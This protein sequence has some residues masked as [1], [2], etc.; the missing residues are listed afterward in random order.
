MATTIKTEQRILTLES[1]SDTIRI[2][3]EARL[4]ASG[5]I[6]SLNGE[7]NRDNTYIGSFS[8]MQTQ[9]GKLSANLNVNDSSAM[10]LA[11][12]AVNQLISDISNFNA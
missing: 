12:E 5:S 10:T 7:I 2:N 3:S 8:V 6:T 9:E 11:T 1:I 4:T